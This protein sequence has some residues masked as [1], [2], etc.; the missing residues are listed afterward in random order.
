MTQK[1]VQ[2]EN[3]DCVVQQA[4]KKAVVEAAAIHFLT[5]KDAEID[6]LQITIT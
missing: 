3:M 2:A 5:Q 1:G 6:Q 4:V